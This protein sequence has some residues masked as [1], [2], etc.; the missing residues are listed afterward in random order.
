MTAVRPHPATQA[1]EQLTSLHAYECDTNASVVERK[2]IHANA[3]EV[4]LTLLTNLGHAK[5][6]RA[7]RKLWKD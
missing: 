4:L 5:I 1:Y 7:Y 6:V 3:D 2:A